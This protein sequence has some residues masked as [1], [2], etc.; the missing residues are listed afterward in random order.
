MQNYYFDL[1]T[2][3]TQKIQKINLLEDLKNSHE[4]WWKLEALNCQEITILE[5]F[6][7]PRLFNLVFDINK[8]YF[9][10]NKIKEDFTIQQLQELLIKNKYAGKIPKQYKSLI[11]AFTTI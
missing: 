3:I 8:F 1:P 9:D 5:Y 6:N 10:I 2:D 11:K 7:I 4:I